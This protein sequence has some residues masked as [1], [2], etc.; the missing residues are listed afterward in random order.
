MDLNAAFV[1]DVVVMKRVGPQQSLRDEVGVKVNLEHQKKS[2][3]RWCGLRRATNERKNKFQTN[4]QSPR[5][6]SRS[7]EK[8]TFGKDVSH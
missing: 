2:C 3:V 6:P 8:S 1:K 7:F 5:S 4:K